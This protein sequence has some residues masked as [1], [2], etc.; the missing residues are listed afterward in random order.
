MTR[1]KH[2]KYRRGTFDAALG[3]AALLV[4]GFNHTERDLE[5]LEEKLHWEL[6]TDA[7]DKTYDLEQQKRFAREETRENGK[8]NIWARRDARR[9]YADISP[10][11]ASNAGGG[12]M[13]LRMASPITLKNTA[14]FFF[15]DGT[16]RRLGNR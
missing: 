16:Y 2:T 6:R 14:S 8:H 4:D 12:T 9:W 1:E 5:V 15:I 13:T 3:I 7:Y 10:P 11:D